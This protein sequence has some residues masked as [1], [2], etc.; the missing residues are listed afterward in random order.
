MSE[1]ELREK[2]AKQMEEELASDSG[3]A[4]DQDMESES[5][6][7]GVIKMDFSKQD[8]N[9]LKKAQDKGI[10]AMKFMK[11]SEDKQKS[12]LKADAEA[13]IGQIRNNQF[14]STAD[15]FG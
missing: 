13:A 8:K 9:K 12:Q 2:A 14:V 7:E 11:K 3:D 5:E 4:N 6:N 10:Q 1:G 15:K